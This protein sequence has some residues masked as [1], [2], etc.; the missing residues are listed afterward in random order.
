MKDGYAYIC[1]WWCRIYWFRAYSQ[2]HRFGS[3]SHNLD[4]L[5]YAA[6]LDNLITVAGHERYHFEQCDITNARSLATLFKIY[7]PDAV[8]H[9]AA[10]SHVD[11][12]IEAPSTF[13][14]TNIIG[15]Y[16]LLEAALGFWNAVGRPRE[17]RFLHVSTDEVFG[18]LGKSGKFCETSPYAPNSPYSATK[19]AGD[20]L[21][22]AWGHTYDLP[23][24]TTNC[25]N[26]YGPYQFPEKLIPV[27]IRNA[28]ASKPI[29]I[30][31]N[32]EQ[33]RDWLYVEDHV[34]ALLCVL[35]NGEIGETYAI[36]GD[37]EF[38]NR[39]LVKKICTLLGEMRP[40]RNAYEDLI[41]HIADRPSHDTRYAI[42]ASKIKSKLGWKP[43]LSLNAGLRK[44]VR[45]YLNNQDWIK[46]LDHRKG[47]GK[48]FGFEKKQEG[49][50]A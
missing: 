41:Q 31:G 24:L 15:T 8:I 20:H 45:W 34:D 13:V 3:R 21:V 40:R 50:A 11:R 46:N 35:Q 44:T 32:G 37:A 48:Q 27:V 43:S 22:R 12:S 2:G 47:V 16:T 26:N 49:V 18:S 29:P 33:V 7:R 5:T 36:G 4:C 9:L 1:N 10:E 14:H 30:Y 28:L 38:C 25:S 6:C 39:D 19:S 42:D 23:V 17:F